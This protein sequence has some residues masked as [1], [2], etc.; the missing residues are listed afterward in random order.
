MFNYTFL[1]IGIVYALFLPGFIF[2]E[3]F[4]PRMIL[5]K[6]I[7][8]YILFSIF[9]SSYLTYFTSIFFGFKTVNLVIIFTILL[10]LAGYIFYKRKFNLKSLFNHRISF[11]IGGLIYL[12]FFIVLKMGI[13]TPFGD[14]FVMSG[15]NW[16]DTAMHLSI[17]ESISQGNFPPHAP[18]F[19]GVKLSYYYFSDF[20]ASIINK[21]FGSFYPQVLTVTNS[22]F[23]FLFFYSVY[24][25][26]FRLI[27]DKVYAA[28][29]GIGAL[30]Y[31]NLGFVN[32]IKDTLS[33]KGNYFELLTNNGYHLDFN[34]SLLMVPM[35]DYFLQNRPM[36]V[37]LPSVVFIVYFLHEFFK[38]KKDLKYLILAGLI[39]AFLIKFQFFGFIVGMIAYSI[40]AVPNLFFGLKKF[41]KTIKDSF[42]YILPSLVLFI[43][44]GFD[45]VGERSLITVVK[46]SFSFG[47]WQEGS[48]WW[49]IDFLITNF[50]IPIFLFISSGIYMLWRRKFELIN[51]YMLTI[52]MLVIPFVIK[53]TI[54]DY[55][56]F[57][58]FY[59]CIPFI[60]LAVIYL[61]SKT[62]NFKKIKML[63]VLFTMIVSSWTS[64]NIL[65]HAYLNK[66]VA[67]TFSEYY[68]GIWIRNN[69]PQNSIFMT[70]PSVHSPV[71]D[72]GGRLRV[73]S[74]IN[75][76]YS[77]GFNSGIDN[78][79][80][81]DTD[82]ITLYKN[83]DD[84][85]KVD[86]LLNKYNSRYIYLGSE[87]TS[88]FI[89]AENKLKSNKSLEIVYDQDNIKIFKRI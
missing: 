47:P 30:M 28:I 7:P 72:I 27:K 21:F 58:F 5:W 43:I 6:K 9:I 20:H 12:I 10:V 35:A 15:P 45:K 40:F 41:S 50:N 79:F 26:T 88:N 29:T 62:K 22:V 81:R 70:Y 89:D 73:L 80:S 39:N 61:F 2:V 36:M 54:Y 67:Y 4:V 8:L 1:L 52:V 49:F 57:K 31:G 87:E 53:F 84:L 55:D 37:G 59:Y 11:L 85:V 17:I 69:T 83:A 56:M 16:Q 33:G 25:L 34:T 13:F 3:L 75:W 48:F 68:A 86:E 18:Y 82:I 44:F 65:I 38:V 76:P 63:I 71:S 23:A 60:Y 24:M 32:L 64:V 74:Y 19:S 78:V 14:N 46:E 51:I 77:H 42:V 66:S